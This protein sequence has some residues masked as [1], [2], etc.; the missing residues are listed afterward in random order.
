MPAVAHTAAM[1]TVERIV[2]ILRTVIIRGFAPGLPTLLAR[3]FAGALRSRGSLA[4]ARS[5]D[6]DLQF[7]RRFLGAAVRHALDRVGVPGI[8]EAPVLAAPI[9]EPDLLAD[10]RDALHVA[11]AVGTLVQLL[12]L[13]AAGARYVFGH[14]SIIATKSST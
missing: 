4:T 8:A 3:R 13:P 12:P 5:R 2:I 10:L 1:S 6:C 7:M 14:G 11:V 9:V